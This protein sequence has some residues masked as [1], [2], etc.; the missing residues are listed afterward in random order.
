MKR[1]RDRMREDLALRGMSVATIDSY[2][3]AVRD[4]TA[5]G[6]GNRP[7]PPASS[8]LDPTNSFSDGSRPH[9][10]RARA[11]AP[12]L[13]LATGV[14]HEAATDATDRSRTLPMSAARPKSRI[15]PALQAR[16]RA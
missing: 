10:D 4:G 3:R 9:G 6:E 7:P 11:N 5:R 15:S 12:S 2:V 14:G 13:A 1:L 8:P 16:A